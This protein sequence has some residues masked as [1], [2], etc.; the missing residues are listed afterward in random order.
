MS[1]GTSQ[2]RHPLPPRSLPPIANL[3]WIA[4][5]K[6][7]APLALPSSTAKSTPPSWQWI[8]WVRS[9]YVSHRPRM[10]WYL[11][12]VAIRCSS[13]PQSRAASIRKAF[14]TT[15]S[16][17]WCPP[18]AR[19]TRAW[20]SYFPRSTRCCEMAKLLAATTGRRSGKMAK[21]RAMQTNQKS[22][23]ACST[24]ACVMPWM[25]A[26]L[27]RSFR[28]APIAPPSRAC[29][30]KFQASLRKPSRSDSRRK[31]TTKSSMPVWLFASSAPIRMST[32]SPRMTWFAPSLSLPRPTMSPLAMPRRC[33]PISARPWPSKPGWTSCS[34]V[35]AAM[36]FLAEIRVMPSKKFSRAMA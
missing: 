8:A 22:L 15:S 5:A 36:K 7:T 10:A 34:R 3:E 12:R 24:N 18:L 20:R 14:S 11:E 31:A 26:R 32:M 2:N 29:S 27:V 6:F 17:T 21:A 28:A 35:M 23:K 1:F 33:R 4:C 25:I 16:L 19:S 30:P 13:I 9:A